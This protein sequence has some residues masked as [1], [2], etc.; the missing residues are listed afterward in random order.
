MA[1]TIQIKRSTGSTAPTSLVAGELAWL[2]EASGGVGGSLWIGSAD[3]TPS[4]VKIA[5]EGAGSTAAD[6]I[7]TGDANITIA[8][9]SG[10][11]ITANATAADNTVKTTTSGAVVLTSAANVDINAT[12]GL[13]A[14][15]T[16]LSI[17]GT[18]DSNLTV[19]GSA[20]DLD[21]AVAGGGTQELRLASAGT[22]ASALHLNAS[23]GSVDI[24]SADNV[25]VDAA[26]NIALTTAG[27]DA[28]GKISLVSGV[29]SDNT[30]I[31]LDGNANAASIVDI[32]AGVLDIDVTGAITMD[33]AGIS[34]DGT[35]T[36]N[37][38]LTSS[39]SDADD[40]LTI[41]ATNSDGTYDSNIN[42]TADGDV[43]ITNLTA[44]SVPTLNQ[45]TTGS[46]A[47]LTTARALQVTLSE[48]DSS[49]F[50]GS[51]NV[52]DI[53]V[54]GTLA[55]G[56][57]G[58][59][60]TTMT[61]LKNALDDETWTFAET[62]TTTG[63]LTVGGDLNVNG[64]TTTLESTNI[65]IKD[66]DLY[67]AVSGG[68][69]Q[70]A[71]WARSGTTVTITS[72]GHGFNDD[73]EILLTGSSVVASTPD[74][75]Y[76]V[77]NKTTNTFEVTGT[78]SGA[79]SGTIDHSTSAVTD[80][81]ANGAGIF[82][83]GADMK[84]IK[85]DSTNEWTTSDALYVTGDV[86]AASGT[87]KPTGDTASGDGAAVGYTSAEGLVL[88]GQGSTSDV[89]IKNDADVTVMSIATGTDDVVF[90]DN[91]TISGDLTITGNNDY[92]DLVAG[93]VP[94]L[95]Q[96]TTG[97][98]ALATDIAAGTV[99]Q[100]VYQ[101]GADATSFLAANTTTTKKFLTGTGTGSAGQAPAWGTLASG[102][103][104]NNAADTTGTAALAEGLTGTPNIS[105]GTIGA[106]GLITCDDITAAADTRSAPSVN[107][108]DTGGFNFTPGG[109]TEAASGTH[110]LLA[111][112]T[113]NP[114]AVTGAGGATTMAA[115]VWI[116]GV[117][118]GAATTNY[119]LWCGGADG[120]IDGRIG[121]AIIDGGTF[122][123]N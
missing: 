91:V 118:T 87:F 10:H 95:N 115:T 43:S 9:G 37:I 109:I 72:N 71:T 49:N 18:D 7:T 69:T 92:S 67:L 39:K 21:I 70:G 117:P 20:K 35:S 11:S 57:G 8:G 119:S 42:I 2:N 54:T 22:G 106:T 86:T 104:P 112:M 102:D 34:I 59:G 58:T 116:D 79:T 13:T 53:G 97:T 45:N 40:T 74:G 24:D 123:Q 85:W 93:D 66:K 98:A 100:I 89:V 32:D 50:N 78:A 101:T 103:I 44:A 27:T 60:V 36:S 83:P 46:A 110:P 4:M 6:D 47:T 31:H 75:V 111:G 82:V 94:T 120:T 84:Y 3:G 48:T 61:A 52:T 105:V 19:T 122:S 73:D 16:T 107:A 26:D 23:A 14:D 17:D 76:T 41:S 63:D 114:F 96:D 113:I 108:S 51:A 29:A 65:A 62:L 90:A 99:G 88:T 12:T 80:T 64:S 77:A 5:T 28:D 68:L 1:N 55:V 81:T 25:T 121:G 56:N 30:A 38:T 15:A 33:G